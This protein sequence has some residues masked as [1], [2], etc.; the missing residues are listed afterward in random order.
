MPL[1]PLTHQGLFW[2]PGPSSFR[3]RPQRKEQVLIKN[4][5]LIAAGGVGLAVF[6]TAAAGSDVPRPVRLGIAGTL[7]VVVWGVAY[8]RG[9]RPRGR[10]KIGGGQ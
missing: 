6:V 10:N 3:A 4:I 7:T 9:W 8:I 1:M 2:E 5:L